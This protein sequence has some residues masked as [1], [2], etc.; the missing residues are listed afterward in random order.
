[1]KL[2]KNKKLK[3]EC[4]IFWRDCIRE[5][6]K[7]KC[8]YCGKEYPRKSRGL[9]A[10]HIFTRTRM[11][12]RYSMANGLSLCYGHHSY[13]HSHP[14]DF[15]DWLIKEKGE[16]WWNELRVQANCVC[17]PDYKLIKLY[18]EANKK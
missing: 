5:R 17:K 18:L 11:N 3:K 15:K 13:A 7:Y 4:D 10:H 9:Q 16:K 6:D 2:L 1:M 14:H 8:A 12:T